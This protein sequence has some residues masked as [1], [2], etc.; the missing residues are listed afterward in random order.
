MET[1][2]DELFVNIGT[3]EDVTIRD[4][5]GLVK[6]TV[7]LKAN[8]AG[9]PTNPTAPRAN[10]WMYRGCIAWAGSTEPI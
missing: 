5:A 7:G 9:I 6:E 4:L 3:G 10:Y 8:F 2:N 1:Y